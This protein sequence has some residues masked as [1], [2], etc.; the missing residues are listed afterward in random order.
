MKKVILLLVLLLS[1]SNACWATL[2]ATKMPVTKTGG[3]TPALQDSDVTDVLG[4]SLTSGVVFNVPQI[5]LSGVCETAWPAGGSQTTGSSLL[6]GNGLGAF[7]NVTPTAPVA[8]S[9]GVLSY[10]ASYVKLSNTQAQN[11]AGGSTTSGSWQT[12]T[13]NTKDI[14]TGSIAT[15]AT[16]KITL[17]AGTY[18]VKASMPLYATST[19]FLGQ[20]RL[21]NN[22]GS[23]VLLNGQSTAF[24]GANTFFSRIDG[25]ITLPGSTDIFLQYQVAASGQATSGQG[26]PSNFGTEVYATIEFLK[27]S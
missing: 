10:L 22:T 27:V 5:C 3:S 14:D 11:T 15:L 4:V 17:P 21:F 13:L 19:G 25:Y 24:G 8:Y 16:N 7:T 2:T 23:V 26:L 18:W 1:I 20:A 12:A 6:A 9:G